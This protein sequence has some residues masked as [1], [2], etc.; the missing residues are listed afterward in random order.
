MAKI[1]TDFERDIQYIRLVNRMFLPDRL[2]W[3]MV[4]RLLERVAMILDLLEQCG[5]ELLVE[6]N[7]VT[8]FID[9]GGNIV[10]PASEN[11]KGEIC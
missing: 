10:R 6:D 1:E 2:T 7:R 9:R 8:G 11:P 3:E 4:R 5:I